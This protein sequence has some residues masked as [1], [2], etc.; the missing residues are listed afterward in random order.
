MVKWIILN[1]MKMNERTQDNLETFFAFVL[2]VVIIY[3]NATS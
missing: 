2:A 1:Q 3:L